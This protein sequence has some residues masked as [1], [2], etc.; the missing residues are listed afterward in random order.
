MAREGHRQCPGSHVRR[1]SNVSVECC[2]VSGAQECVGVV[3]RGVCGSCAQGCVWEWCPGVCVGVVPR[4]VC[5]S[6]AQEC[7]C[8]GAQGYT[9]SVCSA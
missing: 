7:V 9:F 2:A 5:G 3:P 6:G 4:G 8:R 1:G